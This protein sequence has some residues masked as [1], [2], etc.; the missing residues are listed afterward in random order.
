MYLSCRGRR[1][2]CSALRQCSD[3]ER[4][5]ASFRCWPCPA[6]AG[7][8]ATPT[9]SKRRRARLSHVLGARPAP[10]ATQPLSLCFGSYSIRADAV[11]AATCPVRTHLKSA[12]PFARPICS[13]CFIPSLELVAT[14]R[15]PLSVVLQTKRTRFRM[16]PM[17]HATE[18]A[19][20][21][22]A[23]HR[24][25][26]GPTRAAARTRH[27]GL[28]ASLLVT[29]SI[30][31]DRLRSLRCRSSQAVPAESATKQG[32]IADTIDFLRDELPRLFS[33][34]VRAQCMP[35]RTYC[36][37]LPPIPAVSTCTYMAIAAPP[38]SPPAQRP[39][40]CHCFSAQPLHASCTAQTE[41]PPAA[42]HQRR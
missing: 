9:C 38:L 25:A 7:L 4:R 14:A 41:K 12:L 24:R 17:R 40:C 5:C 28:A 35:G 34:G 32:V 23:V 13:C 18:H 37:A 33:T 19:Q 2:L 29:P 15:L 21:Q 16:L 20:P 26:P 42:N 22:A 10:Q 31:A 36:A 3:S 6:C 11:G 8:V 27:A 39:T 30:P 1:C